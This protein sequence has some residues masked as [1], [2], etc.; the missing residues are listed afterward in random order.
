M[1]AKIITLMATLT[2][3]LPS[4]AQ[5][6]PSRQTVRLPSDLVSIRQLADQGNIQARLELGRRFLANNH[7]ADALGWYRKT[8]E[9]DCPDGIFQVG[10][11]LLFGARSSHPGQKVEANPAEGIKWTYHAATNSYVEA[12]RNMS[13]ALQHGLGVRTNLAEAYAWMQLYADR[14]PNGRGALE[15]LGLKLETAVLVEGR[16]MGGEFKHGYW[17]KLKLA[18][19]MVVAV[20]VAKAPVALKL[21]GLTSGKIPLAVINQRTFGPGDSAKVPLAGGGTA[22]VTCREIR[23]DAVLVE[24]DSEEEPRWLT[25]ENGTGTLAGQ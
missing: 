19:S 12:Y 13:L 1:N 21:T 17:P 9:Q 15:M 2:L 14:D 8:A 18:G 6:P 7:H 10:S 5:R 16:R 20:A 11:L 25:F 3:A 4:L 22:T 23:E 24:V